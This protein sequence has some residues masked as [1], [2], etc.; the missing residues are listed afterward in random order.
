LATFTNSTTYSFIGTSGVIFRLKAP[1]KLLREFPDVALYSRNETAAQDV[2]RAS[3]A[4]Q[5][6]SMVG[7]TI[8]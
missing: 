1:K 6:I 3:N 7:R 2:G 8:A 4:I 5:I